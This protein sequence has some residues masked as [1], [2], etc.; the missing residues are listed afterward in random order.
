MQRQYRSSA[1]DAGRSPPRE[2]LV[3]SPVPWADRRRGVGGLSVDHGDYVAG[4]CPDG[5]WDLTHI[6]DAPAKNGPDPNLNGDQY[7]CVKSDTGSGDG[8]TGQNANNKDN[9]SDPVDNG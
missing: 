6:K 3:T 8:N 2:G 9:I 5:N 4:V 1:L 7:V